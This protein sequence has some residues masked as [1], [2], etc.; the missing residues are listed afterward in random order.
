MPTISTSLNYWPQTACA[1]AFWAQQELPAY[2]E[3][4]QA[5]ASWLEPKPGERW[6]D[7]GCGRGALTQSLWLA[8]GGSVAEILGLDC[9]P[10]NLLPYAKLQTRLQPTPGDRLRFFAADFSYG[11][12]FA[13][14][15][16]F[17]GV[18]SGLAIQYAE[19]YS[20]ETGWTTDAY[21]RLL[22][23]VVRVLKP[24]GRFIFSVNVPNP[25]WG[26]VAVKSACAA[27]A[28]RHPFRFLQRAWS[29]LSYGNWLK[30]Q[31]RKGRFHYLHRTQIVPKLQAAGFV[32]IEWQRSFARQAYLFRCWKPDATPEPGR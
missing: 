20:E 12:P 7:L 19:S 6:L 10:A 11:L 32:R 22:G 24:G 9:A 15:A 5:T 3:L 31:A 4:L 29:M 18:V 14:S 28:S 25:S 13:D 27:F 17:D 8:S 1:R 16:R 23:E 21:D 2:Q 26:K 30:R